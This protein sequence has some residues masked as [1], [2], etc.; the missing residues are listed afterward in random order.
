M[1]SMYA[2]FA[3]WMSA[4]ITEKQQAFEPYSAEWEALDSQGFQLFINGAVAILILSVTLVLWAV[5]FLLRHKK[6]V[7]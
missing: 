2:A 1:S 3:I 6:E 4:R 5:N 7:A